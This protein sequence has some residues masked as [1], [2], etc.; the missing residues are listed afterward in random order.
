[1]GGDDATSESSSKRARVS[2]A[3]PYLK[4]PAAT[5]QTSITEG[6]ASDS[7]ATS[8]AS[9][10]QH[11]HDNTHDDSKPAAVETT[12][13]A[14]SQ[15]KKTFGEKEL[16]VERLPSRYVSFGSAEI[17]TVSELHKHA[18]VYADNSVRITGVVVQRHVASDGNVCL[19]MKD[20][21]IHKTTKAAPRSILKTPGGGIKRR[22]SG[23]STPRFVTRKRPL[24]SLKKPS[25]PVNP[26]ES[27][28][29]SLVEQQTVLVY[30]V[31]KQMPVNDAAVGDLVMIIGEVR[32]LP[33]DAV[34]PILEKWNEKTSSMQHFLH[35]RILRNVNGTDMRLHDEA[36]R[37]RRQH[38]METSSESKEGTAF[39][40][41]CGPP[42]YY[43]KNGSTKEMN[44]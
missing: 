12:T 33:V 22:L 14:T 5:R 42:P 2:V 7:V 40:L 11:V 20:P 23:S 10:P 36:L 37:M 3:N 38:L 41:G 44:V 24:S 16:A 6:S 35:A 19:V 8:V 1:M 27:I 18:V 34:Q 43:D 39:R 25:P 32:T 26:L 9:A 21:S 17:L 28:V 30:A 13:T 4:K 29:S 15:E 31:S